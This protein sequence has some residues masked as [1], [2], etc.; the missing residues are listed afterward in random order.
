MD[1]DSDGL[2]SLAGIT[3]RVHTWVGDIRDDEVIKGALLLAE[4]Q[5]PLWGWVNNAAMYMPR[6]LVHE[7]SADVLRRVL[8]VNLVAPFRGCAAAVAHFLEAGRPGAIVNISSLQAT[9]GFVAQGAYAIAKGGIEALTRNAAVEYG[10][11]GIR[12]NAVAPGTIITERFQAKLSSRGEEEAHRE[13]QRR[14][15]HDA[16]GR[17]GTPDEVAMAVAFLLSEQASFITGQVLYVDGGWSS[18]AK[19]PDEDQPL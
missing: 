5:A 11:N 9:R 13:L 4:E 1:V 7:T 19:A 14:G 3:P 16:L 6:C 8:E 15:S 12:V 17:V 18:Q 10:V 2:R